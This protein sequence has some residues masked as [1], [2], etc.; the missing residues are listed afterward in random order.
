[1]LMLIS[2]IL[3]YKKPYIN[4]NTSHVNVNLLDVDN[5]IYEEFNFNTSHVNVNLTD[6]YIGASRIPFQYISC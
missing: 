2:A 5:I 3:C 4:F 1:M 6:D